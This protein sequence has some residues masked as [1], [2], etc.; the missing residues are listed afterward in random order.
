MV[1]ASFQAFHTELE[2][3]VRK[4]TEPAG[5]GH[6]GLRQ[7][8]SEGKA[9]LELGQAAAGWCCGCPG[10]EKL[11]SQQVKERGVNVLQRPVWVRG[12]RECSAGG[13]RG[14]PGWLLGQARSTGGAVGVKADRCLRG[15]KIVLILFLVRKYHKTIDA[16]NKRK[17]SLS[18][19]REKICFGRINFVGI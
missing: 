17:D 18:L 8:R 11:K 15:E 1:T 2:Q 7:R 9:F 10:D 5:A 12:G 19:H 4:P 6:E 13:E 16:S 14:R 3:E